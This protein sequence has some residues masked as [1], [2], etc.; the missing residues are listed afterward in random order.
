MV[1]KSQTQAEQRSAF[2][3]KSWTIGKNLRFGECLRKLSHHNSSWQTNN[4]R[5]MKPDGCINWRTVTSLQAKRIW[6]DFEAAARDF[7]FSTQRKQHILNGKFPHVSLTDS[8]TVPLTK[9]SINKW[10]K[11]LFYRARVT[12]IGK[13]ICLKGRNDQM[14][15]RSEWA[16]RTSTSA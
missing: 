16:R 3:G 15:N 13:S 1:R 4:Q 6:S 11:A 12:V 5:Q 14:A 8:R 10:K 2:A 9:N 7:C